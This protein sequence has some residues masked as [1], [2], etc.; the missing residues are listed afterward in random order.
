[1]TEEIATIRGIPAGH[2]SISP[3]RHRD[4]ASND[5]LLDMIDH[6][7]TVSGRPVGFKTVIGAYGWLDNLFEEILK[8]GME[9]APDFITVD[10]ADGGTGAAPMPLMDDVGLPIYESLPLVVDKLVE[11]G[12]RDRI[13]VIASG[14]LITPTDVAWALCVGADFINS[15]RGF[16]FALGCI[17]AMQCNKNTCPTG[18]TTHDKDLQKGL[19]PEYKAVRVMHYAKNLVKEVGIISHSCGVLEPRQLRRYHARVVIDGGHSEQLDKLYPE[20]MGRN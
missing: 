9:S 12:L 2:D 1:M 18:V 6:I 20:V 3:N 10:S 8:R 13:K 5:D 11:Y 16:M 17:Q 19:N 14:K 7:R 15:A 4:I